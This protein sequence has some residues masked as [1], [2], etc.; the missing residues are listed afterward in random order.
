MRS[1]GTSAVLV[2]PHH[3][4]VTGRR[5][6][7]QVYTGLRHSDMNHGVK[8]WWWARPSKMGE[9][10][11]PTSPQNDSISSQKRG[12]ETWRDRK[13][14]LELDS[15]RSP[16]KSKLKARSPSK[17]ELQASHL[18]DSSSK[19]RSTEAFY[20][21]SLQDVPGAHR[22][23]SGRRDRFLQS[24]RDVCGNSTQTKTTQIEFQFCHG[25]LNRHA[26]GLFGIGVA[27]SFVNCIEK[28]K[29]N[30]SDW[31]YIF[32]DDASLANHDFCDPEYRRKNIWKNRDDNYL[33]LL[34]GHA[35]Q[36]ADDIVDN[37]VPLSFSWGLYG[38]VIP[39]SSLSSLSA[40]LTNEIKKQKNKR[41]RVS[42]DGAIHRFARREGKRIFAIIPDIVHHRRGGF[43]NT[44]MHIAKRD[45]TGVHKGCRQREEGGNVTHQPPHTDT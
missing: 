1:N 20:V 38:S 24:W 28:A 19:E 13:A 14:T 10:K 4:N 36:C 23:N 43:S 12:A 5:L 3:T 34:G 39:K 11:S 44:W 6:P 45:F 35:Y 30:G 32:E 33:T 16:R 17:G 42:H 22:T 29:S 31:I 40:R 7:A 2:L 26:G 27:S 21:I 25:I 37:H 9:Q 15:K 18:N 41:R 8:E